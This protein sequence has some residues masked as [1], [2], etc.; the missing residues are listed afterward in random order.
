[1]IHMTHIN[2]I[3]SDIGLII[4]TYV[5][6]IRSN[7]RIGCFTGTICSFGG[8]HRCKPFSFGKSSVILHST[9]AYVT[10]VYIIS[11]SAS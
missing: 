9:F 6:S 8:K 2:A 7:I 1:M 11:K 4:S 3:T 5:I 10:S